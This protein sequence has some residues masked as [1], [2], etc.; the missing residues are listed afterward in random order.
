MINK[1]TE[2]NKVAFVLLAHDRYEVLTTE[3]TATKRQITKYTQHNLKLN[4]TNGRKKTSV[5]RNYAIC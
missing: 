5:T 3:P 2:N 4:L 1:D